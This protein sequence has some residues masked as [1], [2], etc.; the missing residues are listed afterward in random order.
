[1]TRACR[2]LGL[3]VAVAVAFTLPVAAQEP[4]DE[5]GEVA[6]EVSITRAAGGNVDRAQTGSS[7]FAGDEVATGGAARATLAFD[8]G[9]RIDLAASTRLT[10]QIVDRSDQAIA[11]VKPISRRIEVL[12]GS[13]DSQVADNPRVAT[14]FVTPVG[15]A[16]AK[17]AR[18]SISV[19][20]EGGR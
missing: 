1:M 18:V 7:V 6:G 16:T 4:V 11:G 20:D 19:A 15:V 2:R 12:A 8:D 17:G 9:S 10:V 3:G 14:E 5:I 13:F